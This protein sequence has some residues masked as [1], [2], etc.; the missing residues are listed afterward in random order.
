MV[1]MKL[2]LAF[3]VLVGIFAEQCDMKDLG[4]AD[5]AD[6]IIVTNQSI[7]GEAWVRIETSHGKVTV[8]VPEGKSR[9]VS[10]LAA[11]KYTATVTGFDDDSLFRYETRLRELRDRLETLTLAGDAAPNDLLGTALELS[12]VQA[13]LSQI[14]AGGQSCGAKIVTDVTSHVTVK[15]NEMDGQ[16]G[17]WSLDCG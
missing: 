17:Y 8:V 13:A 11:T 6:K 4:V 15:F 12:Q 14:G 9:T 3:S 7:E 10:V 1:P 5:F 2:L 16:A